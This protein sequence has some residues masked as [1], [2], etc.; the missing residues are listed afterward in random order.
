[1]EHD[2]YIE[3]MSS[4][5]DGELSA[6]ERRELDAHLAECPECAALF[7]EL[8]EQSAAL[9]SLDCG[10]P[11]YLR[12]RILAELPAEDS[13]A[14]IHELKQPPRT[15][16]GGPGR[17]RWAG[18]AAC[19]ALVIA[20]G[21]AAALHGL[22]TSA[23]P[24]PRGVYAAPS[25]EPMPI[26]ETP[27]NFA[28]EP[29]SGGLPFTDS[30]YLRVTYG[31]APEAPSARIIGRA[32]SLAAFAALFPKDDLS[33]VTDAYGDSFFAEGR[34]LAV[35]LEEPSGSI[36]HRLDPDGLTADSVTVLREV[37]EAATDDM[38]VWL[39][40]AEVGPEF[41]DGDT[42]RVVTEP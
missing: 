23:G 25:A 42:L 18:I 29:P 7:R 41:D 8:S 33:A 31:S 35:V 19:A 16:G 4:A 12:D 15:E 22:G 34:L 9:R 20:I 26:S 32:D 38:A 3:W 14:P 24:D 2:K 37:P 13:P 30:L 21:G 39:L 27:G 40:L 10:A 5:L 1:M 28:L 36:R 11:E 6:G 17:R